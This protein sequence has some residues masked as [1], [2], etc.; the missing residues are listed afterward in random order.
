[1]VKNNLICFDLEGPLSPQ[2]NAYELMRLVP[3][4]D[5]LFEVISRYDDLLTLEKKEGYQPGDTLALI[6]PF[7]LYHHISENDIRRLAQEA[8]LVSGAAELISLLK[9]R[10]WEVFCISTSYEQYAL[11]IAQKVGIPRERVSCTSFPLDRYRNLLCQEDFTGV[12]KLEKAI[13]SLRPQKDDQKIK[14]VLDRFFWLQLPPTPLGKVVQEVKPVGGERKVESLKRFAAAYQQP[15]A[16]FMVVGDSI[17][18]VEML[19]TV[20]QAGGISVAFN[21]NE[22]ALPYATIGL[23]S[24][25]LNDLAPVCEAWERGGRGAVA[26][27]V[28]AREK[29]LSQGDREHFHWLADAKDLGSVLEVH[30]RIRRLVRQ[31]AAKLG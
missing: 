12:Q 8:K 17:T 3:G 31:E 22:Y 18:D 16:N 28:K 1:M 10:G 14:E 9:S 5:Q 23:A 27:K 26:D 7:L 24:T 19:K 6:V 15:L 4:G 2:D 20:S 25:H 13:S 30:R 11:A 21:A 29:E